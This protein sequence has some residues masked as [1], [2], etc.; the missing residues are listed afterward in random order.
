M[1]KIFRNF[2]HCTVSPI[3]LIECVCGASKSRVCLVM[4]T[5]IALEIRSTTRLFVSL[6]VNN[7]NDSTNF[8]ITPSVP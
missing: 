1:K 6:P 5:D 4:Q 7:R 2:V 3:D 8:Q